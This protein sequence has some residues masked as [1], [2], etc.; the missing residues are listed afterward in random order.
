MSEKNP[1]R[2]QDRPAPTE[3][4]AAQL[5]AFRASGEDAGDTSADFSWL[6]TGKGASSQAPSATKDSKAEGAKP[7]A[8]AAAAKPEPAAA[9]KAGTPSSGAPASSAA[10]S[11]ALSSGAPEVSTA[12]TMLSIR[13]P[14]TDIDRRVAGRE[15]AIEAKP[16]L[17]RIWQI[18][19]AICFPIVVIAGTIRL[20]ASPLF[21]WVEYFRPGFPADRFGFSTDDRL[22]YGSYVVDYLNNLAGPRF[23]GDL[24]G[25]N[26]QKLFLSTEVSHMADVKGVIS[27]SMLIGF[28][29]LVLVVIGMFYLARHSVGGIRRAVF[30][31]SLATLVIIIGLGVFA[32]IGWDTFFVDLHKVFFANGTWTFLESDTL[33]RLFPEQFWMDAGGTIGAIVLIVASLVFAFNWPT[34]SRRTAVVEAAKRSQG[35]RVAN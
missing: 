1:A 10:S 31:G 13:P 3:D 24:V 6:D 18:I 2:P 7:A 14:K 25:S 35:R 5:N 16:V 32:V 34:K 9:A 20:V 4:L 28:V 11:A 17:P 19:V 23:L 27:V 33:I 8:G 30:A 21:L 22:S 26:G 12:T 29:A 15:E